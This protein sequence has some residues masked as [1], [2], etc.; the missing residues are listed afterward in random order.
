MRSFIDFLT[1]KTKSK[2]ITPDLPYD[3]ERELKAIKE[4]WN[5]EYDRRFDRGGTTH[6]Q[7]M[8]EIGPEPN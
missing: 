6:D 7:I 4:A 8:K 1:E 2:V 5:R 3:E